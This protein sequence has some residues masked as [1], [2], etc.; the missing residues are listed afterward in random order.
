VPPPVRAPVDSIYAPPLPQV[1]WVNVATLRLDQQI[2]RPVLLEFWDFLRVNSLRTLPYLKAWHARYA[3]RGLR[4]IGVH[5]PGFPPSRDA[6][7]A[8]A[9]V[10]RLGIEYPVALDPDLRVWRQ[11]EVPGW[12]ARYLFDQKLRLVEYH[13]GEGDYDGTERAIQELLGLDEPLLEPVRPEDAPGAAL[14]LPTP[15]QPGAWSGPYAAGGV[16]AVV[17]GRGT[18]AA[19]ER[20]IRVDGPACVAL[21]EHPRH[22]EAV[23]ELTPGPGV[24][25]LATCFT[26]GLP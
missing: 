10:A 9:A 13:H 22:T 21:A 7:A 2:G 15:D 23:L 25:V 1:E 5:A 17:D 4:I 19:G 14:V 12:P 18:L 24:T 6:A 8:R 26:A 20:T 3:D 16:W 11:L